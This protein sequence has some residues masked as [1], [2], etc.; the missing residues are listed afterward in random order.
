LGWINLNSTVGRSE[1]RAMLA[2]VKGE[3]SIMGKCKDAAEN[4]FS[5]AAP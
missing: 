4:G 3:Y 2:N 5:L 1:Q